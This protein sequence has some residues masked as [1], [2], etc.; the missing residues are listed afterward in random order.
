MTKAVR[1][2]LVLCVWLMSTGVHWDVLQLAGWTRM[3][4]LYAQEMSFKEALSKTFDGE[5]LCGVC[6]TVSQARWET[7]FDLITGSDSKKEPLM[8][9]RTEERLPVGIAIAAGFSSREI[10]APDPWRLRPPSPP[11]KRLS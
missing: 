11:P 3:I 8:L 5:E 10:A 1:L 4:A 9:A 6:E 7:E 2:V